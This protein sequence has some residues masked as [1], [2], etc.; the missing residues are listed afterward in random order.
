MSV[1]KKTALI[2]FL[3]LAAAAAGVSFYWPFHN[4]NVLQLPGIVE[5]QDVRLGSKIGGRVAEVLVKEGDYVSKKQQSA[6]V[7]SS[8]GY[9]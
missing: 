9:H 6:S 4:G 8:I 2:A 5:I 1:N 3:L 7:T